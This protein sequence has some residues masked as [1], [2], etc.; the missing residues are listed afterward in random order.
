MKTPYTDHPGRI[1]TK[2]VRMLSAPVEA[3]HWPMDENC[4]IPAGKML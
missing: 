4:G 2:M 3:A 1:G